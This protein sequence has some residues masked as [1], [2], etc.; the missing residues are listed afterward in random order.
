MRYSRFA[1][2]SIVVGVLGCDDRTGTS[3]RTPTTEKAQP[4][5]SAPPSINAPVREGLGEADL[6]AFR[7][8]AEADSKLGAMV[9]TNEIAKNGGWSDAD[10]ITVDLKRTDSA[11]HPLLFESITRTRMHIRNGDGEDIT[12][13]EIYRRS[14][15]TGE[16]GNWKELRRFLTCT[17]DNSGTSKRAIGVETEESVSSAH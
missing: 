4:S 6:P 16:H 3:P 5:T 14:Q 15:Y 2:A 11:I 17:K 8:F 9:L 12:V 7:S 13:Y 10:V 1:I